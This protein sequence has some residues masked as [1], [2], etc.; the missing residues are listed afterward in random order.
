MFKISPSTQCDYYIDRIVVV[1]LPNDRNNR[2]NRNRILINTF[3]S[4]TLTPSLPLSEYN[5]NVKEI[6]LHCILFLLRINIILFCKY[7]THQ[8]QQPQQETEEPA[9]TYTQ[10]YTL[11]TQSQAKERH[12]LCFNNNKMYLA[13]CTRANNK[14]A[15]TAICCSV[16]CSMCMKKRKNKIHTLAAKATKIEHSKHS[17]QSEFLCKMFS[18][19]KWWF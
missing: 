5:M 3:L 10:L 13:E 12:S 1:F 8:Q 9:T 19:Q 2:Q 15:H 17:K 11:T 18:L 4:T 16:Y 14:T 6:D 7:I